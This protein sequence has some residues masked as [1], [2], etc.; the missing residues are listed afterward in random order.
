M[1]CA[2]GRVCPSSWSLD[3]AVKGKWVEEPAVR[4]GAFRWISRIEMESQ[5]GLCD[6]RGANGIEMSVW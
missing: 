3:A 2:G 1:N 4:R 6:E 5:G